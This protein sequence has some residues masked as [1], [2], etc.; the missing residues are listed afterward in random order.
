MNANNINIIVP[1]FTRLFVLRRII[2]KYIKNN[3][4]NKEQKEIIKEI[5]HG[6][7]ENTKIE[8]LVIYILTR[9]IKYGIKKY[10]SKYYSDE[11]QANIIEDILNKIILEKFS[12]EDNEM[13]TYKAK[14]ND[15]MNENYYQNLLFNSNDLMNQIFQYLEWG[16]RFNDDLY[17]CSLVSSHWLYHV[18]DANSVYYFDFYA[19]FMYNDISNRKWARMWQRL[20]N[21][22]SICL[23]FDVKY[24]KAAQ[25][26]VNKLSMFTKVEKM[27]VI[28]LH[29]KVDKCMSYVIPIMSRWK[30]RIKY[31]Q[32]QIEPNDFDLENF[33]APYAS[34]LRL[35]KAQHV[36]IGDL[37]FYRIWTN[38]CTR[39]KLFE[40][41][42]INKD[43]CKFLI[44]NCDCS[45]INNLI[46]DR[47]TFDNISINKV[48]LKE[49]TLKFYNLKTLEIGFSYDRVDD[50][51]LLFL[52]LLKPIILKNKTQ[53]QLELDYLKN[54]G[55]ILL[56][57]RMNEKDLKIDKLIISD[58][59]NFDC[60]FST[61][62]KLIQ[63]RDIV[64]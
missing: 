5:A 21:V 14:I 62:M 13:M 7:K 20:Y 35:P 42:Q 26:K 56:C 51:V 34:P 44:E 23:Y 9:L 49:L 60:S 37:L 33:V 64:P 15:E 27:D 54:K 11:K 53:V 48:I 29:D 19:L 59:G 63:D 36:E 39:L 61:A 1:S 28:V 6:F 8:S 3:K 55:H 16:K 17:E 2:D 57:Q 52:Q 43:W 12:A 58:T 50:N 47:V 38:E 32:I 46:L 4:D 18:W 45:N 24:C 25:A 40:L 31:C 10:M 30:D 22:K 41:C